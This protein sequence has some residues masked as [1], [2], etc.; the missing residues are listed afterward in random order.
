MYNKP[1]MV[2][3]FVDLSEKMVCT[4]GTMRTVVKKRLARFQTRDI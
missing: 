4:E 2:V 1:Q 3:D